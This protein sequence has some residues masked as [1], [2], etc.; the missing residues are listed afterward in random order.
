MEIGK[1]Y[2]KV[3]NKILIVP[4]LFLSLIPPLSSLDILIS[5]ET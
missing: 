2:L 3:L 1:R 4:L 5:I